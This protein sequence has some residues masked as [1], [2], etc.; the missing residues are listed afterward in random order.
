MNIIFLNTD[1]VLNDESY[2]KVYDDSSTL[3]Q[4]INNVNGI[5]KV[6]KAKIV[7]TSDWRRILGLDELNEFLT[8]RGL[9][10]GSVI[11]VTEDLGD[12]EADI[13]D[14]LMRNAESISAFVIL[15]SDLYLTERI[16]GERTVHSTEGISYDNAMEAINYLQN[17]VLEE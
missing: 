17:S 6:T 10:E 4:C 5:I 1:G 16:L 13:K 2:D 14:W 8:S 9:I 7:I 11:G 3:P 12:R 15:D